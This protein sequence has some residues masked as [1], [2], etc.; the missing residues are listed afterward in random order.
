MLKKIMIVAVAIV[1]GVTAINIGI[2]CYL[3]Y[4]NKEITSIMTNL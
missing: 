2:N 1:V 3:D 4:A